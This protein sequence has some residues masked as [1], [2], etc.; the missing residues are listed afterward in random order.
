MGELMTASIH[1]EKSGDIYT[2]DVIYQILGFY[3]W[4]EGSEDFGGLVVDGEMFL[5]HAHGMAREMQTIGTYKT[6]MTWES[7][8]R[9]TIK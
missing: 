7:G 4:E 5:L 3:D 1:C 6:T 8:E 9:L 2:A